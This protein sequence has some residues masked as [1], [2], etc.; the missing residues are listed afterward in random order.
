M[1]Y[2]TLIRTH[3]GGARNVLLDALMSPGTSGLGSGTDYFARAIFCLLE[4]EYRRKPNKKKAIFLWEMFLQYNY[5]SP[6]THIVVPNSTD[7]GNA[8][9]IQL[10]LNFEAGGGIPKATFR[11]IQTAMATII[12]AY[13][14]Q[15]RA[16]GMF[17]RLA[18]KMTQSLAVLDLEGVVPS[19]LFTPAVARIITQGQLTKIMENA[20][21]E[22]V[23]DRARTM[24]SHLANLAAL[25]ERV[26][27]T[28]AN[29]GLI[30]SVAK[31]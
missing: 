17:G 15:H 20:D 9:I 5:N 14:T 18:A 29:V 10:S 1:D 6:E 30:S 24:Y 12:A 3:G 26:G 8:W 2:D 21:G 28:G 31:S 25:V 23:D 11:A 22:E 7:Q 19:A 13:T 16:S 27:F 4:R